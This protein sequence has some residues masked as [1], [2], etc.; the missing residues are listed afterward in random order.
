MTAEQQTPEIEPEATRRRRGCVRPLVW[1]L[2]IG[3]GLVLLIAFGA[4]YYTGSTSFESLVAR[5]IEATL[6]SRMDR[7]VTIGSVTIERGRVTSVI[8]EDVTR[9]R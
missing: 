7:E 3:L 8:L 2:L 5:R 4:W 1:A 6:E 9:Q